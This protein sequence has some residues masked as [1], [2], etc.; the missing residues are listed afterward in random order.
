[1]NRA[2]WATRIFAATGAAVAGEAPVFVDLRGALA[3]ERRL[4]P[5]MLIAAGGAAAAIA[6]TAL[7]KGAGSASA[8]SVWVW[9]VAMVLAIGARFVLAQ[10][11]ASA[12]QAVAA[13]TVTGR[14]YLG[15]HAAELVLWLVFFAALLRPQPLPLAVTGACAAI[16]VFLQA[17]VLS[18]M[19]AA[20]LVSLATWV[21]IVGVAG[22]RAGAPGVWFALALLAWLAAAAWFAWSRGAESGTGRA[23]ARNRHGTL[24]GRT[25]FGWQAAIRAVPTPLIIVRHG[26][27]VEVNDAALAFLG[28]DERSVVGEAVEECIHVDPADALLPISRPHGPQN[29]QV[30]PATRTLDGEPWSARVRV[31]SPGNVGSAVVIALTRPAATVGP[32]AHADSDARR[33][34]AWL[35]GARGYPWYRDERGRVFLPKEFGADPGV[36]GSTQG[37]PLLGL[38]ETPDRERAQAAWLLAVNRGRVFDERLRFAPGAMAARAVRVTALLPAAATASSPVIGMIAPLADEHAAGDPLDA[39]SGAHAGDGGLLARLPVLVW[40]IDTQGRVVFTQGADPWRWGGR[41]DVQ[42]SKG[43]APSW[44]EKFAFMESSRLELA[45]ALRHALA[46]RPTFD[47]INSRTTRSGGRIVLRSHCV[48]LKREDGAG[49]AGVYQVLVLDTIASP[50]QLAEIDRLRRSKAQYRALVESSTSL[51]WAVDAAF[52]ITFASRRAAR[53]IYGFAPSELIGQS[54]G[55]LLAP[56]VDQSAARHVLA[57]LR[58]GQSFKDVEMI[59][60]AKDGQRVI[61]SVSA[62]PLLTNDGIFVG[63]LGMNVDLTMLKQR[64]RRLAEALR[65]ERTVLDSAGQAIAVVKD[66]QVARCNDAFLNLMEATPAQMARARPAEFFADPDAWRDILAAADAERERDRA[67]VREVQI[68]RS[69]RAA[70]AGAPWCQL[71]ARAIAPGEYVVVLTDIDHLRQREADALHDAHHD[72]LTGLPNRRLL[73]IRAAGALGASALRLSSCAV[74][75]L[76]L[77]GFKQIND[78]YGHKVG[79]VVLREMASRL[80]RAMRPQDTV[81]R[82]G[83]DEF[84]VLVPEA[85]GRADI[86]RI[87]ERI[88][89]A[90]EQPVAL[91]SGDVTNVS[92][93]IGVAMSP[94]HGRDFERLMQLADLAMYEAKLRGKN[95][96]TFAAA[97]PEPPDYGANVTPLVPRAARANGT[98]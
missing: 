24:G 83:G 74:L 36:I 52:K 45:R 38:V 65:V 63:A 85:G 29:V 94:D 81:A 97:P 72:D 78:R 25:R 67:A 71:T 1:M 58:I 22:L 23:N 84:A 61:V 32:F 2:G 37:F 10:R 20:L 4:T 51:I 93:T 14:L 16:A 44:Y 43:H 56:S 87:A 42:G 17:W 27:V 86:E 8:L 76:D 9:L 12:H 75:A 48:P 73:A 30:L 49:G 62:R 31:L 55:T 69:G 35:G 88:L 6:M 53:E 26:R 91:P 95:R 90:I 13:S 80:E 92:V 15:L 60:Q 28:R 47:V 70:G 96:Y 98:S 19:R 66:G 50:Q 3:A 34:A 59:Q 46:G 40:A 54:V 57:C 89:A 82:R 39:A 7:P 18:A 41:E 11:H 21:L 68:R 79:D 5:A 77:D 33:V 64:E